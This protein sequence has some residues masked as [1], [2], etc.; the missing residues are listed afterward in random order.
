MRFLAY[1]IPLFIFSISSHISEIGAQQRIYGGSD[2]N[3]PL[4]P[5]FALIRGIYYRN[6]RR[7]IVNCGGSLI[8]KN[9]VLTAAHCLDSRITKMEVLLN[10]FDLSYD[11]NDEI[12][13]KIDAED[14]EPHEGFN[15]N[16]NS[17]NHDIGLIYLAEHT[18]KVFPV[19]IDLDGRPDE[20]DAVTLM[21]F[22]TTEDEEFSTNMK[23]VDIDVITTE[24]CK[25]A[26]PFIEEDSHFCTYESESGKGGCSGD[27]GGPAIVKEQYTDIQVGILSFGSAICATG[28][29]A[30]TRVSNYADWLKERVCV[31]EFSPDWCNSPDPEMQFTEEQLQFGCFSGSSTVQVKDIGPVRMKDL[32]IG[33]FV[34]VG[35]NIYEPIYSFGHRAHAVRA[36]MIQI[37]TESSTLQLTADHMVFTR[38]KGPIPASQIRIGC[39]LLDGESTLT[40][41]MSV[42]NVTGYGL[43]SPFT[44]SGKIV[45]D[46]ILSSNYIALGDKNSWHMGILTL[47]H[48]W[49]A[50]AGVTPL[51]VACYHA[52]SCKDETYSVDGILESLTGPLSFFQWVFAQNGVK[53]VVSMMFIYL[54]LAMQSAVENL[55]FNPVATLALLCLVCLPTKRFWWSCFHAIGLSNFEIRGR[56]KI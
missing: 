14:W 35:N 9:V 36:N 25:Y 55:I 5:Y 40:T 24:Y 2:V 7:V 12:A 51:R 37:S 28:L 18:K 33:D 53:R 48:H 4:Y 31:P 26:F 41:V 21:G 1:T 19:Q 3:V 34:H 13:E 50:H 10:V 49:M 23:D 39:D 46:N 42:H 8:S 52:G 15:I 47:N 56:T 43:F 22:G 32:N 45:V 44:P 6:N 16:S 17:V 29:T 30:F 38:N 27:S 11:G 54:A 20:G